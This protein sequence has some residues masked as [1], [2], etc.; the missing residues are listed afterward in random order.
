MYVWARLARMAATAG[1]RG[2]YRFGDESRLSFRCLPSDIDR[3]VHL[4]NARYMMLA[5]VGRIDLFLR[6]GMFRLCRERGWTPMMGGLQ[7]GYVREIKLWKRFDIVTT[8]DTWDA[9]QMIGRHRFLLEDGRTA[10]I[11]LTTVG[12][13]DLKGRHFMPIAE[14]FGLLGHRDAP[15]PPNPMETAFLASHR[16]LRTLIKSF[17]RS[18]TLAPSPADHHAE[19]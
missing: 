18:G 5:D 16:Q 19:G 8:I 6:S 9:T 17:D 7:T 11:V 15:R 10:A 3:N 12:V 4:N 2:P 1:R 13:Y 14:V